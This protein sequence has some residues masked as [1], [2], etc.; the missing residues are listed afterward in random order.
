MSLIPAGVDNNLS[1]PAQTPANTA[2]SR[3]FSAST[4]VIGSSVNSS[5]V[6]LSLLTFSDEMSSASEKLLRVRV[7]KPKMGCYEGK[8]KTL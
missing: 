2:D 8:K 4:S 5:E 1:I 7:Q 6:N 3:E